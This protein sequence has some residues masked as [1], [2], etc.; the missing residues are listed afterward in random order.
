MNKLLVFALLISGQAFAEKRDICE[1]TVRKE[2]NRL[3]HAKEKSQNDYT[4]DGISDVWMEDAE[5]YTV[6]FGYNEECQGGYQFLVI[7]S[8]DGK[9][10]AIDATEELP[11]E[12]G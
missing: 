11:G 3:E 10:C 9:S 2:V 1:K 8:Q 5:T 12:C 6:T 4:F 7:K